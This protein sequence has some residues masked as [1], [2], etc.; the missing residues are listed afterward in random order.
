MA[1][2]MLDYMA[3]SYCAKLCYILPPTSCHSIGYSKILCCIIVW[4]IALHC[5][6]LYCIV[7]CTVYIYVTVCVRASAYV[8]HMYAKQQCATL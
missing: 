8:V 4:Y 3:A 5:I 2:A 6:A 1:Y 7:V